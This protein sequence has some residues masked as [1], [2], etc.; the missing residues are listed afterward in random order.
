MVRMIEILFAYCTR[1]LQH[2]NVSAICFAI[3]F[4][5]TII[6]L[7]FVLYR[8]WSPKLVAKNNVHAF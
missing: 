8:I 6:S 2:F 5:A 7:S 3:F 4:F 1:D